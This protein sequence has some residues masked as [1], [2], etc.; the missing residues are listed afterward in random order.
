MGLLPLHSLAHRTAYIDRVF[1]P[2]LFSSHGETDA[3]GRDKQRQRRP[4]PLIPLPPSPRA[5]DGRE[6][7]HL[8]LSVAAELARARRMANGE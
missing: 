2:C 5:T 6:C 7:V 4:N 3:D 8:A 1:E